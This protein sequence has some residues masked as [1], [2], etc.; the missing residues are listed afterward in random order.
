MSG[1][2][3]EDDPD[4]MSRHF[5]DAKPVRQTRQVIDSQKPKPR[6]R[7]QQEPSVHPEP[8]VRVQDDEVP[9]Y[10]VLSYAGNGI[11]KRLMSQLKRGALPIGDRL[12]L[13]GLTVVQAHQQVTHFLQHSRAS[14]YRCVLVIHGRGARSAGNIPVLKMN[15]HSWLLDNHDVLAFHSAQT[16]DGGTGAVY[17]LLRSP[18][19]E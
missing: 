12:D 10:D 16:R 2:K 4:F 11:Q 7:P 1:H 9:I 13:H 18:G 17:V 19:G 15:V 6:K 8:P 5:P 14:G 3:D